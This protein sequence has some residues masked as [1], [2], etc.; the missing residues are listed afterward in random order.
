VRLETGLSLGSAVRRPHGAP[1]GALDLGATGAVRSLWLGQIAPTGITVSA[2]LNAEG[3]ALLAAAP[4]DGFAELTLSASLPVDA[5]HR[6]CRGVLV[7]LRPGTTY[8]LG[9]AV[10]GVIDTTRLGRFRTP[11]AGP[12]GF[13]FGFASCANTG[14]DAP[15]FDRIR[16]H[17]LD[18]FLHMGDLHYQDIATNDEALF[19]AAY[20][21]V[22]ASP[23][24]N[25]LWRSLPML[26]MWD[27]HDYGP[28]DSAANNP[29]RT[30]AVTA[31]RRRVPVVPH[32]P[33]ALDGVYYS[34]RRGRVIFAILDGRSE[35]GGGN[36]ISAAQEAWLVGLMASAAPGEVLV[37]QSNVP[38]QSASG[39]DTWA[40]A[41]A[42]RARIVAAIEEHMPNR[43]V[44]I[45][46]DMHA[47]A[48]VA[49]ADALYGAPVL[50]AAPLHRS[51]S[52]KGGPYTIGPIQASQHQFGIVDVIDTGSGPLSIRFRGISVNG[53]TGTETVQIDET[54]A[55]EPPPPP[56]LPA[57]ASVEI[58]PPEGEIGTVF[59]ARPELAEGTMP[60]SYAR[61]WRLDGVDVSGATAATYLAS[62][63]GALSCAVMPSNAAG[64][65]ATLV[66]GPVTV[67]PSAAPSDDMPVFLTLVWRADREVDA[68]ASNQVTAW[69]TRAGAH[70]FS[71]SAGATVTLATRNGRNV[72]RATGGSGSLSMATGLVTNL[73][74]AVDI[75]G[76]A[77]V[78]FSVFLAYCTFVDPTANSLLFYS[79]DASTAG[80]IWA[81]QRR[82]ALSQLT[83]YRGQSR[84]QPVAAADGTLS[85]ALLRWTGTGLPEVRND[86]N[87]AQTVNI[88]TNT[89]MLAPLVLGA[90]TASGQADY[91][92]VG[93]HAGALSDAEYEALRAFCIDRW[94]AAA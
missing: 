86:L 92:M 26:Y 5:P 56:V 61:Q 90:G 27:D 89:A 23:R 31:F 67:G 38:W 32:L 35:R 18:F 39:S 84:S 28:D 10:D 54:F 21:A 7:G 8:H 69:R 66:G 60:V 77:G 30:A 40:G 19:Q 78:P 14:S 74:Q 33:D 43:V 47:L 83:R 50:Q 25:A 63:P 62:D 3:P 24:Q 88:G 82:A 70:P 87:A 46:G 52:S 6:F 2:Q 93:L 11:P 36:I 71:K 45:A 9:V 55:L 64:T 68:N 48:Y 15:V 29:S 4:D 13:S 79:P 34:F 85:T 73:L 37:I 81:F 94:G 75:N 12:H 91:M 65:G 58:T 20:D 22:F 80:T 59:T 16:E 53:S 44:V 57:I 51:N 17:D 41:S 42:Q 76:S 1:A 72:V 49:P